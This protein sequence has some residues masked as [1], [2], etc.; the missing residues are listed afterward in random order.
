MD[1][2]GGNTTRNN[3]LEAGNNQPKNARRRLLHNL[4][5]FLAIAASMPNMEIVVCLFLLK[6]FSSLA[7]LIFGLIYLLV[8]PTQRGFFCDDTSIQY[9][10]K[11]DTIPMWMLALYGGLGPVLIVRSF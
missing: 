8:K 10:Y 7:C 1:K 6:S 3:D 2:L 5:D 9:P 11:P 4:Y